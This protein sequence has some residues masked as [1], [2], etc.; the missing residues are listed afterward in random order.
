MSIKKKRLAREINKILDTKINFEKL[1]EKDL[2]ELYDVLTTP[3][4][5]SKVVVKALRSKV[6]D[7]V[8]DMPLREIL[9]KDGPLGLGILPSLISAV[10]SELKD[11]AKGEGYKEKSE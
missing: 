3:S 9:T 11:V 5:L 2:A 7:R 10:R 4:K 6:G 8:L 1:S